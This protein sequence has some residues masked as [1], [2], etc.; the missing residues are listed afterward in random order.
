MPTRGNISREEVSTK[1]QEAFR[2]LQGLNAW[3]RR[4]IIQRIERLNKSR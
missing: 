3:D 2:P 4:R 1:A